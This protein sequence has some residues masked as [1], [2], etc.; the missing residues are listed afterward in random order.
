MA[1]PAPAYGT[2]AQPLDSFSVD[3]R[4]GNKTTNKDLPQW[5][6]A[7]G[8]KGDAYAGGMLKPQIRYGFW[9]KDGKINFADGTSFKAKKNK[10]GSFS[11]TG[12]DGNAATYSPTDEQN[13]YNKKYKASTSNQ[14]FLDKAGN[15]LGFELWKGKDML[16][17]F[18]VNNLV[19]GVDPAGVKLG[20]AL[21]GRDDKPLVDYLGGATDEDFARYGKPVGFAEPLHDAAHTVAAMYGAQGLGDLASAGMQSVGATGGSNL[22]VF[23][24]GGAGGMTGVGG[25]NAGALAA[26]GA[27]QGGAGAAGTTVGALGRASPVANSV[28]G[29]GGGGMAGGSGGWLDTL[30]DVA[31]DIAGM[32]IGNDAAKDA[33]RLQQDGAKEAIAETRRQYD[34]SRADLAPWRESGQAALGQINTGLQT[35]GDFNRDFTIG[36]FQKDPGYQFRMDEGRGALEGSA[37]ARGGLLSGGTGKALERYGQ[38]YASGEYSNAYNRFNNDRNQRFNRLA[39]IAGVGQTATNTTVGAGANASRDVADA[40]IGAA[41]AAAAGRVGQANALTSG[42]ESLG[43]FYRNR[44][45]GWNPNQ[46]VPG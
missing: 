11:Y 31:P 25:G 43:N 41:N 26:S 42:V 17:N 34:L 10:D 16:K 13:A 12:A 29:V 24:N 38:D 6:R 1:V 32:I 19:F 39:S 9:F 22:G 7:L 44:R 15:T 21:T 37:S 33:A 5:L 30:L 8:M 18:G 3:G 36:D 45:Y 23:S 27:I 35:G 14:S 40:T 20:N 46:T 28:S 4:T 2:Q